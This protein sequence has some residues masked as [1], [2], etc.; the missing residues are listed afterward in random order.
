MAIE[1]IRGC[2]YRKVDGL[3]LVGRGIWIGCDRL[4]FPIGSCPV[5]GQGI[6]FARA[7][8]E[9]NPLALFKEHYGCRDEFIPCTMCQPR[10]E[11]AYIMMVGS[12]YYTPQSFIQEAFEQGVSKRIPFLPKKLRLG[13]TVIY[14]AHPKVEMPDSSSTGNEIPE[15]ESQFRLLD[16][17]RK[18]GKGLAIFTSFTPQRVEKLIWES[19][20]TPETLKTLE[21]RGITPVIVPDGDR[22]HAPKRKGQ[23]EY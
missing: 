18:G 14:L 21:K 7:F 9:I 16:A 15:K 2:G 10:S 1:Q 22:D 3:Y 23:R 4:P 19:E 17:Q 20:A 13:E 8:T 12:R 11:L 6:H 5:C